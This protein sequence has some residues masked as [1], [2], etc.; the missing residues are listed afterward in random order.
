MKSHRI[1]KFLTNPWKTTN[2]EFKVFSFNEKKLSIEKA[3]YFFAENDIFTQ[4]EEEFYNRNVETPL[5]DFLNTMSKTKPV[6]K[7]KCI[8]D[9]PYS[10]F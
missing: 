4:Q 2:G 7:S 10:F 8:E 6:K 1:P 5:A 3:K 9:K